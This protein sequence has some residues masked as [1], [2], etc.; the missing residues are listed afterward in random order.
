MLPPRKISVNIEDG[1]LP[2]ASDAERAAYMRESLADP[3][4][5]CWR[6]LGLNAWGRQREILMAL[7]GHDRVTVRSGHG[8]GKSAAAA[9]AVIWFLML[10]DPAIVL[11]TAPTSRQVKEVLWGEIHRMLN[12]SDALRA[13]GQRNQTEWRFDAGRFALGLS[14]NEAARFQG[15]HS[16]NML[17][18]VDE[19]AGVPE[20]I[21]D[22]IRGVLTN[23]RAKL[24][25]IGNPTVP[26]G[27]FY[28]SHRPGSGYERLVISAEESPNVAAGE[29]IVPGLV[30]RR[31]VEERRREWGGAS[32]IYGS[33]VL[34][35]FPRS[36]SNALLSAAAVEAAQRVER[37]PGLVRLGVDVAR[38][39]DDETVLV[40]RS[41]NGIERIET[42]R[43]TST[44]ET[45]GLT[46]ALMAEY[47]V[48]AQHVTV[49]D[50]GIGGGVVDGLQDRGAAVVGVNFAARAEDA[51]AYANQRAEMWGEM[52]GAIE[53]G[54]FC[55]APARPG[56][57]DQLNRLVTELLA[58]AYGF[59]HKGRR[60][61]EAKDKI[62]ARLGRS[63]DIADALALTFA[64]GRRLPEQWVF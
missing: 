29:E 5:W 7:A 48:L 6:Y 58:P 64:K 46:L 61:I 22:A 20:P 53:R 31:W 63:P 42:R 11:T 2:E 52:A 9:A 21:F 39:G 38:Y 36:A 30:G 15:F 19:A 57:T 8:V 12:G 1:P 26:V 27:E 56:M 54:E 13:V 50:T 18:V 59:D 60:Q 49:D 34:G 16:P 32:A 25:L 51:D 35:E 14:T 37:Q 55:L 3:V 4:G 40:V 33:R 17:V 23:D 44:T 62:K 24:L 45:I 41:G 10:H 28:R 47:D 43:K